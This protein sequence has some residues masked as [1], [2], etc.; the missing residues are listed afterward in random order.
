MNADPYHR[1]ARLEHE[2][3]DFLALFW[4]GRPRSFGRSIHSIGQALSVISVNKVRVKNDLD[5]G[6]F[7]HRHNASNSMQS[8]LSFDSLILT[9]YFTRCTWD[10]IFVGILCRRGALGRLLQVD[11]YDRGRQAM[12][13]NR[14]SV[15][16]LSTCPD[17]YT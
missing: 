8:F 17:V 4:D 7:V 9:C 1:T 6:E 11:Y 13:C 16:A 12:S 15:H 3:T 14:V 10:N 2:Q 5:Q